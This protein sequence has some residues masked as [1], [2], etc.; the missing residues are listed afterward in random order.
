MVFIQ[1]NDWKWRYEFRAIQKIYK[2]RQKLT[3]FGPEKGM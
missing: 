3:E 1:K 2:M